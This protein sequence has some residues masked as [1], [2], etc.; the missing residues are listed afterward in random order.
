MNMKTFFILFITTFINFSVFAKLPEERTYIITKNDTIFCQSIIPGSFLTTCILDDGKVICFDNK[1]VV[2]YRDNFQ[3]YETKVIVLD[4]NTS[5]FCG[6]YKVENAGNN[7][8]SIKTLSGIRPANT[9][10]MNLN[11]DNSFYRR[12]LCCIDPFK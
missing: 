2:C 8:N 12:I 4:R 1:D 9:K 10:I 11:Q 5:I 3:V 6:F 7:D